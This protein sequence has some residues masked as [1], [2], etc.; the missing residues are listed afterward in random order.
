[1]RKFLVNLL[2]LFVPSQKIRGKIRRSWAVST[3]DKQLARL[4]N[5]A[6]LNL[7][8]MDKRFTFPESYFPCMLDK[9]MGS[10][11]FT[12]M[13]ISDI[14]T[15]D[16][17]SGVGLDGEKNSSAES[18]P[19]YKYLATGDKEHSRKHI[20]RYFSAPPPEMEEKLCEY[21]AAFD[22]TCESL[23]RH[24]YDPKKGVI[25]VDKNNRLLDGVHRLGW[26]CHKYGMD[27]R[28]KVLKIYY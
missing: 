11:I 2:C 22:S 20:A 27:A 3:I 18:L 25:I 10:W 28:I 24:G 12:S 23:D 9:N 17:D 8:I 7:L 21:L 4:A 15:R 26:L 1:M 16:F 13:R 5:I 6:T 19:S 14:D